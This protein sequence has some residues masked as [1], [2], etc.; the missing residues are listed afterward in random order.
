HWR[1]IDRRQRDS[2]LRH[3]RDAERRDDAHRSQTETRVP[4]Q[5]KEQ[6]SQGDAPEGS[7]ALQPLKNRLKKPLRSLINGK[8]CAIFPRVLNSCATA[9]NRTARFVTHTGD[10]RWQRRTQRR[11]SRRSLLK[12]PK[13]PASPRNRWPMCSIR[14]AS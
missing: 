12:F 1:G 8:S 4:L 14:S 6:K 3:Q 9:R 11:L 7:D 13:T 2:R 5:L 10:R